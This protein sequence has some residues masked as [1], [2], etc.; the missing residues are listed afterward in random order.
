MSEKIFS[1]NEVVF[2]EGE[3]G[4]CFYEIL[5]GVA[6]I[7]H[8][9]GQEDQKKLTEMKPGQYFGE[10]AVIETWPRSMTVVAEEELRVREID[11]NGLNA[12][13]EEEPDRILALMKQIGGRIRT[14]TAEYEEVQAFL[15]EKGQPGA[16]KKEGFLAKMRKYRE[17]AAMNKK[18]GARTE[19]EL[20]KKTDILFPGR[21]VLP[22]EEYRK[23]AVIFREGDEGRYMYA[24]HS[25]KVGI[26]VHYGE[27][28]EQKLTTLYTN[29]FFGEMGM[30]EEERR[31]ATA[32][33]EE[34]GTVLECI[35]ADDLQHLFK[36]NPAE[37]NAIL[38]H[39]SG[40]LRRL[41][42]D[43]TEACEKAA[44]A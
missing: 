18:R 22:V 43:Y 42:K 36:E 25:G 8:H 24:I 7:Y 27:A 5:D 30:I 41:S 37:V 4:S 15:R 44:E 3:L 17:V 31:S 2:R 16:E 9:W 34:E 19:E 14:V 1:K 10:M 13:F 40:R 38:T 28:R 6:G 21:S 39:L 12:F 33:V 26:C 11:E 29:D 23:G 32:V 35:R 20:I